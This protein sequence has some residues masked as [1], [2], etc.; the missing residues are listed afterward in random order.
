MQ[1][2]D[3]ADRARHLVG[4]EWMWT[5]LVARSFAMQDQ[6]PS[7]VRAI[8]PGELAP[9]LRC[10]L[11]SDGLIT[12]SLAAWAL[13][14]VRVRLVDQ[15]STAVGED[16]ACHLSIPAGSSLERRRVRM[17]FDCAGGA[18][19]QCAYAESHLATRRL[20]A[21]FLRALADGD[22]I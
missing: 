12:R 2:S 20:P 8:G 19:Q 5:E 18:S 15:R 17:F 10:L 6:R 3:I 16:T 1:S 14:P 21:A 4:G 7:D 9:G 11:F 13:C 22:G